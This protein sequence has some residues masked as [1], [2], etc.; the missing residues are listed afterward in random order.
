MKETSKAMRRRWCEDAD[1]IFPWRSV[2][3]GKGL[4]VGCGDDKI[5]F[6]DCRGFD[7]L[8]GDAN[9]LDKH[10]EKATFDYV[11][12]SQVMEHLHDPDD[13][14]LRWSKLVKSGGHIIITVPSW[15]LYEGKVW[16]SRYNP[17]HKVT[18]SMK[19]KESPAPRHIYCP[20]WHPVG[21]RLMCR[22]LDVN[23]DHSVGTTIDQT[24]WE[25]DAVEPW[26]EFVFK[27]SR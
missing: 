21:Q 22:E 7:L 27:I 11:H 24:L 26:I 6:D 8:D 18:W 13:A 1:G 19:A 4:D 5:P 16:P 17:D 20:D 2:F 23:Y 3:V 15:E 9:F 14:M 12:G 25:S 10:F